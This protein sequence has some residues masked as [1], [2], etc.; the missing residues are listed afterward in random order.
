MYY[1]SEFETKYRFS[2]SSLPSKLFCLFSSAIRASL[3][4]SSASLG[5]PVDI[6][7]VT[8]HW[9][10]W[11]VAIPEYLCLFLMINQLSSK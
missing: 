7:G 10:F 4:A 3:A 8:P 11:G 1:L 2:V 6:G 9:R 5:R